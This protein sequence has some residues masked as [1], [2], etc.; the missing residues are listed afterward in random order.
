MGGNVRLL[1]VQT[2]LKD[3]CIIKAHPRTGDSSQSQEPEAHCPTS[4]DCRVLFP[5]GLPV[6][7]SLSLRQLNWSFFFSSRKLGRSPFTLLGLLSV[8]SRKLGLSQRYSLSGLSHVCSSLIYSWE[9]R[10]SKFDQFRRHPKT[11]LSSLLSVLKGLC[12]TVEGLNVNED[13]MN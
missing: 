2:W 5:A 9:E 10:L 12:C 4:I 6:G 3:S 1:Q 7:L 8:Y 11:I 13:L